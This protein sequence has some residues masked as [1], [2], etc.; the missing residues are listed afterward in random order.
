MSCHYIVSLSPFLLS[1]SFPVKRL[2]VTQVSGADSESKLA[3]HASN[4]RLHAVLVTLGP[5]NCGHA[6]MAETEIRP[7][8][9]GVNP[10]PGRS[11]HF[12]HSRD[13]ALGP[14]ESEDI[15]EIEVLRR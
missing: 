5:G 2:L 7:V 8:S 3:L 15:V 4:A 10:F 1:F 12:D 13:L 9:L 14:V 6:I 11:A